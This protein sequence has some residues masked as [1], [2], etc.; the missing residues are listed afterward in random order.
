M[1]ATSRAPRSS[2][3]TPR[4]PAPPPNQ[5]RPQANRPAPP[6]RWTP[7]D[8]Q[9]EASFDRL[10]DADATDADRRFAA[11]AALP[12]PAD[13][14]ICTQMWI[15][16]VQLTADHN[17]SEILK[18]LESE[19]QPQIWKDSRV[20]LRDFNR[21]PRRGISFVC[22][23]DTVLSRLGGVH[24]TI[25]GK[26]VTIRK[27]SRF[28]KL[29][30]VDLQRLPTDVSD[31][32]IYDW[33]TLR[34]PRP[35]LITPTQVHGMLSSRARTVYFNGVSCP[36]ELF[37]PDHSPLREIFF[38]PGEKPCFVQHRLQRYNRVRPPSLQP[39]PRRPSEA[40]DV[41]MG[42]GDDAART[43]RP[44]EPDMP[45]QSRSPDGPSIA[46]NEPSG[47]ALDTAR[48]ATPQPRTHV[49]TEATHPP[50]SVPSAP[51]RMI[52]NSVATGEPEWK[53]IQHSQYGIINRT[54]GKFI[55]PG[56]P[57]PCELAPDASDPHALV[58]TVPVTPN[59]Y[60]VLCDEGFDET[61]PPDVDLSAKEQDDSGMTMAISGYTA[62]THL[63][64]MNAVRALKETR[65]LPLKVDHVTVMEL[66]REIDEFLEKDVLSYTSHED[67]LA[68]I[69]VQPAYFRRIF[70]LP[71]DK[72]QRLFQAHAVYRSVCSEP[73]RD[74]E[75]TE[76]LDRLR[77][78]FGDEASA[79]PAQLFDRVY[80]AE[81]PRAAALHC[82]ISDM[83]LMIFAP[84][85]YI[86]PVKIQALLPPQMS[87][88][89]LRHAP[90]LLWGDVNLLH[91]A[92]TDAVKIFLDDER[93]PQHVH[94]ALSHLSLTELP[95]SVETGPSRLVPPQL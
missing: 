84:G 7:D 77:I 19:D 33:F 62:D 73:V 61:L 11:L 70:Q 47:P 69:Q 81:D 31:Q 87:P 28:D 26:Q 14:K 80:P 27:Y 15:P 40:S 63:V 57:I 42:G 34:G 1:V 65:K 89:R 58:Y 75:P 20:F 94:A 78:R 43:T 35:V 50:G 9:F 16:A 59:M 52:L 88:K 36:V 79:N 45:S 41:S 51:K 91:L 72:Q 8:C 5:A 49:P 90:F 2:A 83:F 46:A 82:A 25:C 44:P 66:Q 95:S 29:Y 71:V 60:D 32:A 64:P 17:I 85:I 74:G 68:A 4:P 24:L 86:D 10:S 38:I 37:E 6:I 39:P 12:T 76:F 56:T 22:T 67:V 18:S 13:A 93:T 53:L 92:R 54:G 48:V 21:I 30:Y 23:S 3:P 55:E